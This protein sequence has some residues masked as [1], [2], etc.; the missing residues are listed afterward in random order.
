[1]KYNKGFSLVELIIVIAIMAILA[2]AIA[3]ALIR[4]INKARKADDIATAD[5]VGATFNAAVTDNEDIYNFVTLCASDAR[6]NNDNMKYRVVCY[7]NAGY[8]LSNYRVVGFA[9]DPVL[10]Q[11]A[12]AE[13]GVIL[14]ELMGANIYKLKFTR[15]INLDQWVIAVD[16]KSN[17]YVFCTGGFGTGNYH[18]SEHNFVNGRPNSSNAYM[19]WPRVDPEYKKLTTPNDV[20]WKTN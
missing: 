8:Q 7:M 10:S 16:S 12:N 17:F 20:P 1:M 14:G 19:I 6:T 4:Y 2:A 15:P 5:S 13:I 18:I 3:P 11:K 9:S